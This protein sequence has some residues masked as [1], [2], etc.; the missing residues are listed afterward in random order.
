MPS[1][2]RYG[3][4]LSPSLPTPILPNQKESGDKTVTAQEG[5]GRLWCLS[6][7]SVQLPHPDLNRIG[8][9][10]LPERSLVHQDDHFPGWLWRG[11]PR[12]GGLGLPQKPGDLLE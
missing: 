3:N 9:H 2:G 4:V 5:Q 1:Q 8:I 11:C 7:F 10:H 12:A 6:I